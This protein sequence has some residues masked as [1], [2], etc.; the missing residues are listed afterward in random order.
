VNFDS[1]DSSDFPAFSGDIVC[2]KCENEREEQEEEE[3]VENQP[4]RKEE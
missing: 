2:D 1:W 3:I 4:S